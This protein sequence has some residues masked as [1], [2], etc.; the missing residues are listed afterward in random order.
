MLNVF[1]IGLKRSLH[2]IGP[3]AIFF[4]IMD[5][6]KEGDACPHCWHRTKNVSSR[7][8]AHDSILAL[9]QYKGG[10]LDK[11]GVCQLCHWDVHLVASCTSCRENQPCSAHYATGYDGVFNQNMN[12]VMHE[13]YMRNSPYR[14]SWEERPESIGVWYAKRANSYMGAIAT[15]RR[16]TLNYKVHQAF[17]YL[18]KEMVHDTRL[19]WHELRKICHCYFSSNDPV[20][21]AANA[22][23]L[24]LWSKAGGMISVGD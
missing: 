7:G 10:L 13:L 1:D 18:E 6:L 15:L 14:K 20:S 12:E 17:N 19:F 16:F 4:T 21:K 8:I 9:I 22:F 24:T 23:Y 3:I 11:D 5:K 2:E